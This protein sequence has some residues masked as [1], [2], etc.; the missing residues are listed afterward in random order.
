MY[1]M[2]VSAVIDNMS[3]SNREE[4]KAQLQQLMQPNPEAQKAQQEQMSLQ[5][6]ALQAQVELL[7]SQAAESQS[8]AQKL[9]LEAQAVP[10]K[11]ENDRLRA[12]SANIKPGEQDDME[13]QR[14]AKIAELVLKEREIASKEA[15]VAQQMQQPT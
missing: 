9:S 10:A 1:P 8:R 6:A 13:F 11:V 4:L 14:R 5:L 3:L 2:L 7:Q 12:L 15:I